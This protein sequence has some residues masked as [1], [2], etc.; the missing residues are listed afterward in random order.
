MRQIEGAAQ[1]AGP[2]RARA[3]RRRA[4]RIQAAGKKGACGRLA[5]AEDTLLAP[6]SKK[7]AGRRAYISEWLVAAGVDLALRSASVQ[8]PV[9]ISEWLVAAGVPAAAGR[10]PRAAH[11]RHRHAGA[12]A[13]GHPPILRGHAACCD[14]LMHVSSLSKKPRRPS[15]NWDESLDR[16]IAPCRA[17]ARLRRQCRAGHCR[18]QSRSRSLCRM[19]EGRPAP[20]TPPALPPLSA[21]MPSRRSGHI[22]IDDT[23]APVSSDAAALT[24]QSSE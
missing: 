17:P 14:S 11:G 8:R 12:P 6:P 9:Y 20:R 18:A 5:D 3:G 24:I 2:A 1:G 13:L 22:G 21:A 19:P 15:R 7:G 4:R 23:P 16:A 10:R